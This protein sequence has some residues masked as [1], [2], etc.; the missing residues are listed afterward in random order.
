MLSEMTLKQV[1]GFCILMENGQGIVSKAP[2][3]I[4]EK[5]TIMQR[6]KTDEQIKA[7]LDSDNQRKYD[8]WIETWK[9]HFEKEV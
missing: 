1:V 6:S 4:D 7:P 9:S 3:Y 2:R 8:K 5:M